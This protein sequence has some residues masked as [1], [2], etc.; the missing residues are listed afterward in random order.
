MILNG[1]VKVGDD[2]FIGSNTVIAPG[3]CI[4]NNCLISAGLFINEDIPNGTTIN[5]K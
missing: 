4:G 3:K 2:T 5:Y 1:E